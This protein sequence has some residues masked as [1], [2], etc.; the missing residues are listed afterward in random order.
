MED[1][2]LF[3]RLLQHENKN[4]GARL[5]I[6]YE[7]FMR[8]QPLLARLNGVLGLRKRGIETA[9]R[10]LYAELK[11]YKWS[12]LKPE[13]L[14]TVAE[15]LGLG[16][17]E[18]KTFI[19]IFNLARKV[20]YDFGKFYK[21]VWSFSG[22]MGIS[23]SEAFRITV[24]LMR[25]P[26]HK[27]FRIIGLMHQALSRLA[28]EAKSGDIRNQYSSI[29]LDTFCQCVCFV[30]GLGFE[31]VMTSFEVVFSAKK[32]RSD[33]NKKLA[34]RKAL[35][36]ILLSKSPNNIRAV[37]DLL[38]L[39]EGSFG[40]SQQSPFVEALSFIETLGEFGDLIAVI[41]KTTGQEA[42]EG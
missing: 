34:I 31:R 26:A 36:N 13:E 16:E 35:T 21:V 32:I 25:I 37:V 1:E 27:K 4:V 22:Q 38:Q 39:V 40:K 41:E 2:E 30:N 8:A 17:E 10:S 5:L 11:K 24:D 33:I 20:G 19:R 3:S 7:T 15:F 18:T 6:A 28:K 42:E 14:G 29:P 9:S 23:F 12:G